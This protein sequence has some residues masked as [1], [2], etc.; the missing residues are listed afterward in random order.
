M[1]DL[2][3]MCATRDEAVRARRLVERQLETLR[4]QLNQDK[5]SIVS[6]EEGFDFLGHALAPPQR[7]PRLAEGAVSFEEAE[8]ALR[9]AS[10]QVQKTVQ[11]GVA[12]ASRRLR[13]K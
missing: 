10:R 5:M 6:Y 9:E 1:D 2:V 7:G 4:L 8:R 13:R 3:V 11:D 12:E